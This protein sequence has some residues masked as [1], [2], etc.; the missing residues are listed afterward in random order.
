M[1]VPMD[2]KENILIVD[3]DDAVREACCELLHVSGYGVDSARNGYDAL[4]KIEEAAYSVIVA[5]INMPQVDGIDFYLRVVRKNPEMKNRFL[6]ITGDLYGE[7]DALDLYM[8]SHRTVLKKPFTKAEFLK[9][10]ADI[11]QRNS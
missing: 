7:Q 2:V 4:K 5:D 11:L 10:I 1:T 8:K 3:D 6:F 9:S